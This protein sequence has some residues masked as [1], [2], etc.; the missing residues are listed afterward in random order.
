MTRK[1]RTE[2]IFSRREVLDS[3]ERQKY[4]QIHLK[5]LLS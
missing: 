4:H 2:G 5:K 3:T 1:D